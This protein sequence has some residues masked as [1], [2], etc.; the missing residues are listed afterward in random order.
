[1]VDIRNFQGL[2]WDRRC[3]E[4]KFSFAMR[5]QGS[6]NVGP[7]A[8]ECPSCKLVVKTGLKWSPIAS[9]TEMR[10]FWWL[11]VQQLWISI[12]TAPVMTLALFLAVK[13]DLLSSLW[14]FFR[15][16]ASVVGKVMISLGCLWMVYVLRV[17]WSMFI[18]NLK[19]LL[20]WKQRIQIV[21]SMLEK[22]GGYLSENQFLEY[23]DL[24][25]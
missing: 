23:H 6:C 4:C 11:K 5:R 25:E 2:I 3:P 22:T 13:A 9:E 20:H 7:P 12:L 17:A 8:I 14:S 15:F 10:R 21:Q 18:G 1:M 19:T 24:I 16:D